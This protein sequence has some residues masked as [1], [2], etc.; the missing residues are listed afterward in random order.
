MMATT[1]DDIRQWFQS[2][3][4]S[5]ATHMIVV[6]DTYDWDD[7]PVYVRQEENVGE[8]VLEY[9]RKNMQKGMEVYDLIMDMDT[10]LNEHRAFHGVNPVLFHV[11]P[12]PLV[13]TFMEMMM[14]QLEKKN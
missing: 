2:G 13:R 14:E 6:C 1:K 10:Q 7:Y 11:T 8:K 12:A 4:K 5:G 9:H 3:I